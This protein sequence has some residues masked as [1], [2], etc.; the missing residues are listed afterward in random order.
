MHRLKARLS[1]AT[2]PEIMA[3]LGKLL[4]H[5]PHRNLSQHEAKLLYADYIDEL[6]KYPADV[7]HSV[8][9]SYR[10]KPDNQFFPSLSV[11]VEL[12]NIAVVPVV[13]RIRTIEK[14]LSLQ[15]ESE[16]PKMTDDQFAALK[17]ACGVKK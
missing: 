3:D 14:I 17:A 9:K 15:A 16:K 7:V 10:M 8:C 13:Q 2:E 11:L 4:L 5:C 12:M 1:P 6:R